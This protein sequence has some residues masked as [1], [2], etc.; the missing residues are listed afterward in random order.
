MWMI[1]IQRNFNARAVPINVLFFVSDLRMGILVMQGI[2]AKRCFTIKLLHQKK[3]IM[4][5][6]KRITYFLAVIMAKEGLL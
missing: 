3:D 6:R 5:S 2:N 4:H 1:L